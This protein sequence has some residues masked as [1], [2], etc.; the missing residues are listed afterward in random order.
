MNQM[1]EHETEA[2]KEDLAQLASL[3]QKYQNYGQMVVLE[4]IIA[5]LDTPQ[6]DFNRLAGI[7]MWGGAGAVWESPLAVC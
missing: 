5:T 4:E 1:S 7:E 2:L 6:P 3:H